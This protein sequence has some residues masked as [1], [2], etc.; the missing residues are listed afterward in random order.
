MAKVPGLL[1]IAFLTLFAAIA[2]PAPAFAVTVA[3]CTQ[4]FADADEDDDGVLSRSEIVES[5]D[6]PAELEDRNQVTLE[7]F[8][9]ECTAE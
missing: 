5:D 4:M 3:Q 1:P 2:A 8:M 6:I 9:A 7:E